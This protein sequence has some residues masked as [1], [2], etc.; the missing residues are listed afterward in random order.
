MSDEPIELLGWHSGWRWRIGLLVGIPAVLA[1]HIW[2]VIASP[3]IK[4]WLAFFWSTIGMWVLTLV[5]LLLLFF[6]GICTYEWIRWGTADAMDLEARQKETT[7]A[8]KAKEKVKAE[9][10]QLSKAEAEG[11]ELGMP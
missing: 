3:L 7:E 6:V 8:F 1:F 2:A 9:K 4:L 11:G 5:V 10:G